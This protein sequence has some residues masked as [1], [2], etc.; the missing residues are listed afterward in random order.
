[1]NDTVSQMHVAN[2]YRA[3]GVLFPS[4]Q[5]NQ[6]ASFLVLVGLSRVDP[7]L[8]LCFNTVLYWI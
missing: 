8:L 7:L 2:Y 5:E 4:P 6:N 1:M 3:S